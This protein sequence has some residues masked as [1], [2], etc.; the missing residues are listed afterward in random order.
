MEKT[1]HNVD[2]LQTVPNTHFWIDLIHLQEWL[3]YANNLSK[4]QII[5]H[6]QIGLINTLENG[7][8]IQKVK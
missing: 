3:K 7:Y 6:L 4:E 2:F 1:F 5:K 8:N